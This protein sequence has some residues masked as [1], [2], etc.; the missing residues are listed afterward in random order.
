MNR[1]WVTLACVEVLVER[2][3]LEGKVGPGEE[4]ESSHVSSR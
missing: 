3:V 4:R 2:E 1:P